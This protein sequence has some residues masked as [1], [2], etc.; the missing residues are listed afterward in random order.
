M[1]T[2]RILLDVACIIANAILIVM[3]GISL[4]RD[5]RARR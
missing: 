2:V 4:A 3:L 1:K 5:V